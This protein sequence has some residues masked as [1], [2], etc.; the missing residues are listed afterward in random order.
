MKRNDIL[1]KSI[2]EDIFDD[3]L[4]FFFPNADGLFQ[5][6]RG[7]EYL[8]KE[9][10]QLFPPESDNYATRY[11]DKLVK[12]YC[13]SGTEAWLLVHV[14]VQGYRDESFADRMFTYYY[15][16][17]DKYRQPVTAF[18]ILTDECK[19]FL[20]GQFEQAC[21]GTSLSF[22]FNS[23][24][25]LDQSDDELAGSNNPFAQVI[26]TVKLAI[27]GECFSADELY[28][29]KIDLAKNLLSRKIP[30]EKIVKLMHFLKFYVRLGDE[31]LDREFNNE[32]GKTINPNS[33]PMTIEE[34]ILHIVK[35]EGK[36]EGLEQ[37]IERGLEQ[38]IAQERI[39]RNTTF[40]RNLLRETKFTQREI[41]QLAG[42]TIG[43]VR[44]I[45]RNM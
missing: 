44:E 13:R 37:G 12:V 34:A 23:F 3:F 27:N 39:A 24:K 35:E 28:R 11:V 41:A 45:K 38:G 1:W 32:I 14:E 36:E 7:F 25:V 22:R 5:L 17:W 29:L 26:Q 6:G 21:L 20:P 10:E 19:H 42:V 2:L 30:K 15:R 31:E 8:D 40:V 9:L 16:I 33:L 18:A 43:F 4:R